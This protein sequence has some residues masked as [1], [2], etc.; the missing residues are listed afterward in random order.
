MNGWMMPGCRT[1]ASSTA[2]CRLPTSSNLSSAIYSQQRP[3]CRQ[4]GA[5]ARQEGVHVCGAQEGCGREGGEDAAPTA[6]RHT[7]AAAPL[8][9]TSAWLFSSWIRVC[10]LLPERARLDGVS[11]R[12]SLMRESRPRSIAPS[13]CGG[14]LPPACG[15]AA[16]ADMLYRAVTAP[17]SKLRSFCWPHLLAAAQQLQSTSK[18]ARAQHSTAS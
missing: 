1:K 17:S 10:S 18:A 12:R 16:I 11:L 2:T 4:A 15:S 13:C 14:A 8:P 7:C 5:C 3:S 9:R 6:P